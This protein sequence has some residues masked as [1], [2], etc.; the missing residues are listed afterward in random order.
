MIIHHTGSG[1]KLRC[2][3]PNSPNLALNVDVPLYR[4]VSWTLDGAVSEEGWTR[5]DKATPFSATR[6]GV[7]RA[8]TRSRERA[9]RVW[10]RGL[11]F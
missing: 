2:S 4:N 11:G 10:R 1:G 9:D 7:E 3:P 8:T 5:L 6:V